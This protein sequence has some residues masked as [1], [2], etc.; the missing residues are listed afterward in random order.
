MLATAA[1]ERVAREVL[2]WMRAHRLFGDPGEHEATYLEQATVAAT[3]ACLCS[4]ADVG[5]AELLRAAQFTA[6]FLWFD[7][8]GDAAAIGSEHPAVA[9]WLRALERVGEGRSA[10]ADFRASFADYRASLDEERRVDG[11]TLAREDYLQLRRRTIFVEPY[12]DHWR[13]SAG[14]DVD[15]PARATLRSGQELA[16]DLIILAN[17]L[18]SLVRDTTTEQGEMNLI[19][20]DAQLLG[21]LEQAVDDAIAQYNALA[22]QLRAL[23]C[24]ARAELPAFT[25]LLTRVVDGNIA[26]MRLL[27]RRYAQSTALLD[28]LLSVG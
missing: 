25:Q 6:I 8:S 1:H 28:R 26:T 13:V 18:G 2:A 12:L 15:G 22:E 20:R 24:S 17:E 5:E 16:R 3:F 23:V 9:E 21:S 27:T 4:A 19:V 10:L 11:S 7:D 14:I